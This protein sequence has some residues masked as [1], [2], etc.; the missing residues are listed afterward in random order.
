MGNTVIWKNEIQFITE[1]ADDCIRNLRKKDREFLIANPCAS[2]HHHFY[3]M[4]IRNHYIHNRDFS[5][6]PSWVEPDHL[7]SEIMEMIF[8]KLLSE[9]VYGDFFIKILYSNTKFL[10]LRKEHKAIYGEYPVSL[11]EKYKSQVKIEPLLPERDFHFITKEDADEEIAIRKTNL[12]IL[13][14]NY[15]AISPVIDQ[16][17][18]ELAEL[19]WRTDLLKKTAEECGISYD[20][21]SENIENMKNIFYSDGEFIPLQVC[22]LSYRDRIGTN[23]YNEYR[24]LLAAHLHKKPRLI[25][26]LDINYFN[27]RVLARSA[28]K[29]GWALQYLPMYQNDDI[30]VRISLKHHGEAIQYADKRFQQDREWIKYAIEHSEK[31]TIMF[32]DCM[33]PYRKDKELVYLACKI[34]RWNF[35]YV[36]ESFRDDFDLAK[37]CLQQTKDLNCIYDY[38]SERLKDNKELAMLDLQEENPHVQYYSD[39]LRDDDEIAAKLFELHGLDSW[40]WQYLSK[41]L[42]KKYGVVDE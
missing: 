33:K 1:V 21:I 34:K 37:I 14:K 42:K 5:D 13:K 40:A 3:G 18:Q 16:L 11:V 29:Y 22:F 23:R 32:L 19:V 25:E 24:R 17:I 20:L 31:S 9:Y 2:Y 7:S 15:D 36:D 6:V 41:R 27:D 38:L 30:M 8:S 35:V 28:L 12:E 10:T 26:K 39:R 4:Y